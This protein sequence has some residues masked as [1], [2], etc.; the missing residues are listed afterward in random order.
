M[1]IL[2]QFLGCFAII[3]FGIILIGGG[4]LGESAPTY[5]GGM[6]IVV[7]GIGLILSNIATAMGIA[8]SDYEFTISGSFIMTVVTGILGVLFL[9][10]I[11]KFLFR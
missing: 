9:F 10:A 11:L 2:L 1:D 3:A 5:F 8:F 4:A 7:G 6:V